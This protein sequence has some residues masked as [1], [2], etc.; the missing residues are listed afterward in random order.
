M[1]ATW[2]FGLFVLALVALAAIWAVRAWRSAGPGGRNSRVAQLR[3]EYERL[4]GLPSGE[5]Y[6]SLERQLERWVERRPGKSMEF[7]LEAVIR[8]LQR[9][10]R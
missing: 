1:K 6:E 10:R 4:T 2:V 8:D 7:Y 5:A 9:D 3:R